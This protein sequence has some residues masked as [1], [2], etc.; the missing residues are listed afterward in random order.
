M[1]FCEKVVAV[2]V[3]NRKFGYRYLWLTFFL[4]FL[5]AGCKTQPKDVII[6]KN[7][8]AMEVHAISYGGIIT[9]ILVP[10]RTGHVDDVVLGYD[11]SDSYI[12]DNDPFMGAIIGRYGNRIVKGMFT[13]DGQ[14]YRLATNNGPNHLHGG[15]KGFDKVTW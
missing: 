4:L 15:K 7:S 1:K 9:S 14:T 2:S 6:L 3:A 11:N 10:D 13:L 5:L 12:K 8:H